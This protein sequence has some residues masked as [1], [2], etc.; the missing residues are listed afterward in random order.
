M[1]CSKETLSEGSRSYIESYQ[2]AVGEANQHSAPEIDCLGEKFEQPII[3][4][5]GDI[6]ELC[7][8]FIE[9]LYH[10]TQFIS[11]ST[12]SYKEVSGD[13]SMP[14]LHHNGLTLLHYLSCVFPSLLI[15]WREYSPRRRQ[16]NEKNN[17][18][19]NLMACSV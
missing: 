4:A 12:L 11:L 6:S 14:L 3:S 10:S 18:F 17:N 5:A 15:N 8:E 13:Y 1:D 2:V 9:L 19:N 7:K 16:I